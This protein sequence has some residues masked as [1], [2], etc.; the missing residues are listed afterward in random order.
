MAN[1]LLIETS[2]KT[3]SVA[4]SKDFGIEWYEETTDGPH[5][6][7]ILGTYVEKAMN[8]ARK[9]AMI[10]DAIAVSCGPGSYTGLR[11]GI[12]EAKG[13]CFGLQKP[14]IAI[15]TLQT[16]CCHVMFH[17]LEMKEEALLCPMIDAR[18]MEVYT[19]L[20]DQSLNE[21]KPISAEIIDAQFLKNELDN[22]EI[23]FFGD[24]ADK[25]QHIIQHPNAHFIQGVKPLAK[26][27]LAPAVKAYNDSKFEDVAYFVPLYLKDF[28]A[29]KAKNILQ[30]L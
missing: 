18:R 17:I 27:M 11:I 19:V 3:C 4:L 2:G 9:N 21:I 12:S 13:L 20:Y 8:F 23:F 28:V 30:T 10:P 25:C 1:L 16:M 24:G 5:H 26:D 7:S 29:T 15:N 22:H 14:L 6:A